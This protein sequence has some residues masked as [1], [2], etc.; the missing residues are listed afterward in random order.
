MTYLALTESEDVAEPGGGGVEPVGADGVVDQVVAV[1]L[2]PEVGEHKH[3]GHN[4]GPVF[5]YVLTLRQNKR[6]QGES[7]RAAGGQIA[8]TSKCSSSRST[9][10]L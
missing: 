10:I 9:V 2:V 5:L 1:V 7:S 3:N 8:V 4:L 6:Q